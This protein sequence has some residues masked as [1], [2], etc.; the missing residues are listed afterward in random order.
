MSDQEDKVVWQESEEHK[1][2]WASLSPERKQEVLGF[3]YF[4]RHGEESW[5]E[6]NSLYDESDNLICRPEED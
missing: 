6:Y 5:E 2:W 1:K 3:V 4:N